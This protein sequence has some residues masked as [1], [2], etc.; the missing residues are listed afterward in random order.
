MTT[1]FVLVLVIVFGSVVYFAI[2]GH[3]KKV[4]ERTFNFL[5]SNHEEIT[6][7]AGSLHEAR[8]VMMKV[9]S[10]TFPKDDPQERYF[11]KGY[12]LEKFMDQIIMRFDGFQLKR[13]IQIFRDPREVRVIKLTKS[14]QDLMIAITV[15]TIGDTDVIE[16][17]FFIRPSNG[18][19]QM[20]EKELDEVLNTSLIPE[21][22]N[23]HTF[24]ILQG[25][26]LISRAVNW[27]V[28]YRAAII[29]PIKIRVSEDGLFTYRYVKDFMSDLQESL[30]G[31]K[32][33]TLIFGGGGSGKTSLI[34][35]FMHAMAPTIR[36]DLIKMVMLSPQQFGEFLAN[37]DHWLYSQA[38]NDKA[39]YVLIADQVSPQLSLSQWDTLM[40]LM[41]GGGKTLYDFTFLLAFQAYNKDNFINQTKQHEMVSATMLRPGRTKYI[42]ELKSFTKEQWEE[43]AKEIEKTI[44]DPFTY[45]KKVVEAI[46]KAGTSLSPENEVSYAELWLGKQKK[47]KKQ[48][49]TESEKLPKKK[50][51]KL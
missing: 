16:D 49:E 27:G 43:F 9:F 51:V 28:K 3:Q 2:T 12:D 36:P 47:D 4:F 14:G 17:V 7:V 40:D 45:N 35:A 5:M 26:R 22:K 44:E 50:I 31:N 46:L 39:R 37:K 48:P 41:E 8:R 18:G 15:N 6:E 24:F 30:L 25:Q 13:V 23:A 34:Q 42:V 10:E 11:D 29:N 19:L 32:E 33:H 38:L 1:V 21:Y 20:K